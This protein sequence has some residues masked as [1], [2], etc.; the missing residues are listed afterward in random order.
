MDVQS[1]AFKVGDLACVVLYEGAVSYRLRAF[2]ANAPEDELAAYG[3]PE[4]VLAP[5]NCLVVTTGGQ[6]VLI[7]TGPGPTARPEAGWILQALTQAGIAPQSI[8]RVVLTHSHPDH[9]G[10]LFDGRGHVAFPNAR[11]VL[12]SAEWDY[13][14]AS[15]RDTTRA[16][17]DL[18]RARFDRIDPPAEVAPGVRLRPAPG[19]TPGLVMV[20]ITG[21]PDRLTCTSDVIA[22]PLHLTHPDWGIVSDWDQPLALAARRDLLAQASAGAWLLLGYHFP[23]PGLGRARARGE[24]YVWE[25]AVS[26]PALPIARP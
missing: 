13:W 1:Y 7:D 8:D 3:L 12:A 22:H 15:A 9:I 6:R 23:F 21:G 25:P 14:R 2:F 17:L 4:R 11:L 20:E 19:H 24:T 5:H 18:L 26:E 10:G 16:L